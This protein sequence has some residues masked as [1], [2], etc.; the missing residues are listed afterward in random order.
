[1][2][3]DPCFIFQMPAATMIFVAYLVLA[4]RVFG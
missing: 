3:A 2:P 1:M 4:V